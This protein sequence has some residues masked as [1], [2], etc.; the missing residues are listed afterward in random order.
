MDISALKRS[1][2]LLLRLG[3]FAANPF[4]DIRRTIRDRRVICFKIRQECDC[5]SIDKLNACQ[6]ENQG[7]TIAFHDPF[8]FRQ[9]LGLNATTQSERHE[10]P[11][12]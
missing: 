6:I 12:L 3:P 4:T 8:Q 1:R 10:I 2:H 7:L 11:T 9:I 5:L